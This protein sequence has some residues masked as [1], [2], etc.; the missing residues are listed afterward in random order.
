M[1]L[2]YYHLK[3]RLERNNCEIEILKAKMELAAAAYTL[4]YLEGEIASADAD[5]T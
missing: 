5:F 1:T 3:G 2:S 4:L